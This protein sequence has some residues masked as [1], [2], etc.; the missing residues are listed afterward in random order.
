MDSSTPG[1]PVHHHL[2]DFAQTHVHGVSDALQPSR[3]LSSPSPLGRGFLAPAEPTKVGLSVGSSARGQ[4]VSAP[5]VSSWSGPPGSLFPPGVSGGRQDLELQVVC[6]CLLFV[7]RKPRRRQRSACICSV[8]PAPRVR[9]RDCKS[10][11]SCCHRGGSLLRASTQSGHS[12]PAPP[13]E[14]CSPRYRSL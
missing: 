4:I 2:L 5:Q 14:S 3:P 13:K 7:G 6:C 10:R 8:A 11:W 12:I 9:A 1:L